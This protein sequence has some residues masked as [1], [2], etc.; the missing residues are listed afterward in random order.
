[1]ENTREKKK[2]ISGWVRCNIIEPVPT[3]QRAKDETEMPEERGTKRQRDRACAQ[4]VAL[5]RWIL[6]KIH[7]I[8]IRG[9]EKEAV[10]VRRLAA[11]PF[12]LPS[13]APVN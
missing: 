10:S 4:L 3:S 1:M 9:Q 2:D 8:F 6:S 12:H 7:Q 11:V 13:S 5:V